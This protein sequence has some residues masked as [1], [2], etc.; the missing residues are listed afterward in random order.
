MLRW[1]EF[2]RF[3]NAVRLSWLL[4]IGSIQIQISTFCHFQHRIFHWEFWRVRSFLFNFLFLWKSCSLICMPNQFN[5][6]KYNNKKASIIRKMKYGFHLI[7]NAIHT[8][9]IIL[10]NHPR[11]VFLIIAT[12]YSDALIASVSVSFSFYCWLE[13]FDCFS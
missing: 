5:R 13:W 6:L 2:E 7:W 11:R 4:E 3:R 8:V 12:C 9:N 1:C 10:E